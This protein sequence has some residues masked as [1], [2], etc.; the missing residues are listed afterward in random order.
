MRAIAEEERLMPHFHLSAQS[1]D[2]LILKRMKRRHSRADTIAFCDTVRRLR[3]DAAFGA[4]LIAGFPTE[5]EA[6]FEN[7]LKLVDDA[8]SQP[9]ACLSFLARARA[10]RR[11]GCRNWRAALA[12]ERARAPA[13]RRAMQRAHGA[14]SDALTG[15]TPARCW[16]KSRGFGHTR[17]FCAGRVRG[18]RAARQ[19]LCPCRITGRPMAQSSRTAVRHE[20]IRRS[21]A[22]RDRLVRAA[23][24]G[25]GQ[26]QRRPDREPH[27]LFTKKK[28]DAE[29]VAELEEAL[30]RADMGASRGQAPRRRRGQEPL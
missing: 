5:S 14:F 30:I 29:T 13:R 18:R 23:E 12:K 6:M 22:G 25:P 8:G 27:R 3:P 26:I 4:D 19:P 9:A 28:L 21:A 11:R 20:N 2:D 7:S 15:S 16:W 1:G 24:A 10:R 17:M